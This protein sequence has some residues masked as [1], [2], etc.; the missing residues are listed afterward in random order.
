VVRDPQCREEWEA[1]DGFPEVLRRT[2]A[3]APYSYSAASFDE[4]WTKAQS[5]GWTAERYAAWLLEVGYPADRARYAAKR[6][7]EAG[8]G[9]DG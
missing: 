8:T 4:G 7:A 6:D 9:I 3:Q 5:M 2:I 1:F